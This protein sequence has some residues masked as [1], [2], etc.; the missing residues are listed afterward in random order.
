MA[1]MHKKCKLKLNST[2]K[3]YTSRPLQLHDSSHDDLLL[4]CQPFHVYDFL[5]FNQELMNESGNNSYSTLVLEGKQDKINCRN[6]SI[7]HMCLIL[8]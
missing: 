3:K 2:E 8:Q 5:C 6:G 4:K 7:A 1:V